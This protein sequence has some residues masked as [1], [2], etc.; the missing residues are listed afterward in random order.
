[1][2]LYNSMLM[3]NEKYHLP[4]WTLYMDLIETKSNPEEENFYDWSAIYNSD[5]NLYK[6][7][8]QDNIDIIISIVEKNLIDI[9]NNT[10]GYSIDNGEVMLDIGLICCSKCN[11]FID[12]YG[13]CY[14]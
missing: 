11:H 3:I 6:K 7:N 8:L 13:Y 2:L 10:P 9:T 12:T 14:C 4:C 1:M 5:I